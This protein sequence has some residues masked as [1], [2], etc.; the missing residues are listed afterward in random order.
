MCKSVLSPAWNIIIRR[1]KC[2]LNLHTSFKLLGSFEVES[3]W[4]KLLVKIGVWNYSDLQISFIHTIP[5]SIPPG[6][7]QV[8][9][10]N[11]L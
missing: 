3:R 11:L 7:Q 1:S 9:H 2:N 10:I 5:V 4:L 6:Q 8:E